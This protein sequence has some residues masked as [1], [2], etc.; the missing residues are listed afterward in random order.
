M[1]VVEKLRPHY[2][3]ADIRVAF[4]DPRTLNRS[5]VSKQGADTL[6]MDD[7]AVVN[8]I[9]ALKHAD[10][11]KSMTSYA[12]N[13]VW[14][15]VYKPKASGTQLYVKFTLDAMGALLLISFKEA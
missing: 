2:L 6:K 11:D 5:F 9:Q 4:A 15:D 14:Q 8:V 12:N 10:F 13:Q 1:G 3:L 7:Q